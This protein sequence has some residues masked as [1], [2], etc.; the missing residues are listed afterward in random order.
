MHTR[1]CTQTRHETLLSWEDRG[2]E[3]SHSVNSVFENMYFLTP[4]LLEYNP[5]PL[6][7]LIDQPY[8]VMF[9]LFTRLCWPGGATSHTVKLNV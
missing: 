1:V 9:C 5:P 2:Q 7:P 6:L 4:C 3:T 8:L